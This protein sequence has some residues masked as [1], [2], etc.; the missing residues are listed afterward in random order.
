M[1]AALRRLMMDEA[2]RA[3]FRRDPEQALARY[4]L[5]PEEIEALKDGDAERLAAVGVDVDRWQREPLDR[6]WLAAVLG[7]LAPAAA[8]LLLLAGT[9]APAYA[10]KRVELRMSQ[11]ARTRLRTLYRA[12]VLG[13]RRASNRQADLGFKLNLGLPIDLV[14]EPI[15]LETPGISPDAWGR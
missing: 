14:S 7:R 13:L 5:A 4:R 9:G 11:R 3:A 12:R 6:S 8:A 10:R 1:A 15:R 2:F